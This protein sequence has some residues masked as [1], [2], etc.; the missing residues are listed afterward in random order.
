LGGHIDSWDVGQGAHDDGAGLRATWQAVVLM[1]QLGLKPRRTIRVVG[2]TGHET[3]QS[4]GMAYRKALGTEVNKHVA[5][6]A[7]DLGAERP[8]GFGFTMIDTVSIK[9]LRS[10]QIQPHLDS[11]PRAVAAMIKLRQIAQLLEEIHANTIRLLPDDWGGVDI[12]P[13][14][15]DGVPG[16]GLQ[17]VDEHYWDWHHSNADTL[18][19]VDP[20]DFRKCVATLAVMAYVLADMPDRL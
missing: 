4:G 11:N 19:K 6:I 13:L 8:V 7:M 20:Q 16:L 3:G 9:A 14:M 2:W 15:V 1:N 18:D 10:D 5:A 12:R 17:T